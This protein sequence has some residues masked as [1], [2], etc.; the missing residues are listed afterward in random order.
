VYDRIKNERV[1]ISPSKHSELDG[2]RSSGSIIRFKKKAKSG[3]FTHINNSESPKLENQTSQITQYKL[4]DKS[5]GYLSE[6][7]CEKL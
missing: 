4:D 1:L 2:S 3:N 7:L 5:P 6:H